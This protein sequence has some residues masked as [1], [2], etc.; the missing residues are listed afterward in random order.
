MICVVGL[1]YKALDDS[2]TNHYA[3]DWLFTRYFLVC[4]VQ[5]DEQLASTTATEV[6]TLRALSRAFGGKQGGNLPP[7][8]SFDEIIVRERERK[9]LAE[10]SRGW[11]GEYAAANADRFAHLKKY[12]PPGEEEEPN[13]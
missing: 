9:T 13:D 7:L 12:L 6:G 11:L 10:K 3:L 4:R 1:H 8:P 2:I 5:Y